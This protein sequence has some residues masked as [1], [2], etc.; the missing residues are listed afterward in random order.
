MKYEIV[1]RYNSENYRSAV[2]KYTQDD[3]DGM[4]KVLEV[5]ATKATHFSFE[6]ESGGYVIFPGEVLRQSILSLE[7]VE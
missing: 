4:C 2:E 1:V 5:A 3:F 6:T 7:P